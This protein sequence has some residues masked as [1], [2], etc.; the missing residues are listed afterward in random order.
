MHALWFNSVHQ[1]PKQMIMNYYAH[2]IQYLKITLNL[3]NSFSFVMS[4]LCNFFHFSFETFVDKF[5]EN[6]NDMKIFLQCF[7]C[8][9]N[10]FFFCC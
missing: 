7:L 9:G 4:V 8:C 5:H 2:A 1:Y 10:E 6:F 3:K